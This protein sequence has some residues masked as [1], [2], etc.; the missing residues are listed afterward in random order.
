M[1]PTSAF[2]LDLWHFAANT[3]NTTSH[4]RSRSL[5]R[6]VSPAIIRERRSWTPV[7]ADGP[8]TKAEKP[9]CL[10]RQVRFARWLGFCEVDSDL[11]RAYR[12]GRISN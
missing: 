11:I 12:N 8:K 5:R 1:I 7:K 10:L 9:G 2:L 4:E 3:A 6:D